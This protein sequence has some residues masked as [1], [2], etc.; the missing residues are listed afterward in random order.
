MGERHNEQGRWTTHHQH[1]CVQSAA[2][3]K[4]VSEWVETKPWPWSA[5][6]EIS[7][8][9]DDDVTDSSPS[10]TTIP[11]IDTVGSEFAGTWFQ[12]QTRRKPWACQSDGEG[13]EI[14]DNVM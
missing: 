6:S 14:R 1:V 4:F 9:C 10:C 2:E 11:S 12:V 3:F 7:T 13:R 5:S 8:R